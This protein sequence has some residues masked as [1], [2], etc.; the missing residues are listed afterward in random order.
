LRS[1]TCPFT[2]PDSTPFI[3]TEGDSS[4]GVLWALGLSG[5]E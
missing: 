3:K 1:G 2:I 5:S 4:D